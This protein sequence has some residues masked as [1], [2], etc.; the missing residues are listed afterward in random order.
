MKAQDIHYSQTEMTPLLVNPAQAGAQFDL[1]S[2]L[3]YKNQ[4]S[5]VAKAY[6]TLNFSI[7]MKLSK[8]KSGYSAGKFGYSSVGINV[9]KDVAGDASLQ[10]LQAMLSYSYQVYLNKRSTLGAGLSG[11]YGQRSIKS[12]DFQ[13]AS[14]FDGLNYNSSLPSNEAIVINDVKYFDLGAGVHYEFGK[15]EKYISGNNQLNISAGIAAFHLNRPKYSFANSAEKLDV[16]SVGYANAL[17]GISNSHISI[18]PGIIY[19]SQGKASELIYGSMFRYQFKDE[20]KYTGYVKGSAISLGMFY[21]NKDAL[22]AKLL[23]EFS[24]YAIGVSYDINVSGLK[25]ASNGMGGIEICIRFVNP[26]PFTK[27]YSSYF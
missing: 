9:F 20:S 22:I 6:K 3:N 27:S 4:W 19:F 1:R 25:T 23:F 17:I 15:K 26:N 13:W 7:E 14:Q 11:S 10:T 8:E 5:S 12:E 18:A 24:K 16:K 2:A 21:R